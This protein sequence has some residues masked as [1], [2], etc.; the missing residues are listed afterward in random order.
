MSKLAKLFVVVSMLGV[1]F[2]VPVPAYAVADCAITTTGPGSINGCNSS[3]GYTCQVAN[4]NIIVLNSSNTQVA[5]SGSATT[6]GNTSS[7]DASTGSASNANGATFN[8]S[9]SN[10]TCVVTSVTQTPEVPEEPAAPVRPVATG[11]RGMVQSVAD[12]PTVLAPTSSGG[13]ATTLTTLALIALA[14]V[15]V[16]RLYA[17]FRR[18]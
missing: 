13:M 1:S 7:G 5:T 9:I 15:G 18:A 6:S 14:S 8:F 4:E 12:T 11:G 2:F 17:I 16:L 10:G 3:T